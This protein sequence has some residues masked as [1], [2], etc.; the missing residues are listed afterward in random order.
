MR[1]C[2]SNWGKL[3]TRPAYPKTYFNS[4]I[5]TKAKEKSTL[6]SFGVNNCLGMNE[7]ENNFLK[8]YWE[9]PPPPPPTHLLS[10]SDAGFMSKLSHRCIILEVKSSVWWTTRQHREYFEK[11]FDTVL[12][13]SCFFSHPAAQKYPIT[14]ELHKDDPAETLNVHHLALAVQKVSSVPVSGQKLIY[15][16]KIR[17][18]KVGEASTNAELHHLDQCI[19]S[20]TLTALFTKPRARPVSCLRPIHIKRKRKQIQI[21]E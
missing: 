20:A 3:T 1:N 16:G 15:K 7:R 10:V 13:I 9:H 17:N 12:C 4:A 18:N 6:L 8:I 14:L 11:Q 21:K 5:Y 19:A 2:T